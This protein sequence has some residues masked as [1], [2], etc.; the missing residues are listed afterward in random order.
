MVPAERADGPGRGT[1]REKVC[2][3]QEKNGSGKYSIK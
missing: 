2:Q 1:I 3:Q